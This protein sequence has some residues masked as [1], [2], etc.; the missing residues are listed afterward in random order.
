M[1]LA[2]FNTTSLIEQQATTRDHVEVPLVITVLS[3]SVILWTDGLW[4]E[5][6][7]LKSVVNVRTR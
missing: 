1:K 2:S 6:F 7:G 3:G 4:P 5:T